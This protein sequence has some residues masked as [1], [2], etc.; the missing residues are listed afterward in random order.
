MVRSIGA[1]HA[2]D[3]TRDDFTQTSQRYNVILDTAG[4]RLL[5]RLRGGLTERGTL[6]IVGA[7]GGARW[8]GGTH[9]QLGALALSSFVR[10]N[11]RSF[12][13]ME[14]KADLQ[15]L[16]ELIEASKVTPVI[17]RTYGLSEAPEA[18]R[19]LAEG[20]AQGKVVITN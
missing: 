5:S 14:N 1:D 6:V 4:N 16:K 13:P 2:I 15:S 12:I 18:I 20:H 7:E 8:I 3:Y 9:R 17:D 10:H 11:L 19:Y